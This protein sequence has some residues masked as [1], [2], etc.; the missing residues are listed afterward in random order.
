MMS[1]NKLFFDNTEGLTDNTDVQQI[2]DNTDVQQIIRQHRGTHGQHR[3]TTNYS[4][5]PRDSRTTQTYNKFLL[6][7]TEGLTD[8]TDVQQITRQHRG[9]YRRHRRTTNYSITQRTYNKLQRLQEIQQIILGNNNIEKGIEAVKLALT[10]D[11]A[12]DG[13][14]RERSEWEKNYVKSTRNGTGKR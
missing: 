13:I 10:T 5:T 4:T 1:Y 11:E 6:D 12:D 9:T 2:T 8:N 7:N 14:T 3:R